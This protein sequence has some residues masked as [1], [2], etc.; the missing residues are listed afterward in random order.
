MSKKTYWH[1]DLAEYT[2]KT[3]RMHG[4]IFYE[5]RML[6]GHLIGQTKY[7]QKVPQHD[8]I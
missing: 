6:E 5:I 7:T 3:I 2:G 4:G 8:N 1:G